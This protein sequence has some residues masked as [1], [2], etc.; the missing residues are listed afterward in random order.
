MGEAFWVNAAAHLHVNAQFFM[1]GETYSPRKT[2]P[3]II[4]LHLVRVKGF[5]PYYIEGE[6]RRYQTFVGLLTQV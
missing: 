6:Q 4:P 3:A 5:K 1:L 2:K